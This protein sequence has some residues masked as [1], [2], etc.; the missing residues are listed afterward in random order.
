LSLIQS[1]GKQITQ[2]ESIPSIDGV[3]YDT[4]RKRIY[5]TGNSAIAV[6]DQKD[7][8]SY[9]PMVKVASETDSQP[10]LWVPQFNRLYISVPSDG[11]RD[12]EI[13]V[14]EP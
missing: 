1:P 6:Y 12:A 10:S 11:A 9:A 13:L 2:L 3:W 8:D 7:A 5:V 4:A 14:Y